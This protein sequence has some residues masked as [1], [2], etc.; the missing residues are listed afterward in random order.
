MYDEISSGIVLFRRVGND[1]YFLLLHYPAGHWDFPKGHIE[2]NESEIEAAI[3]ELR[4]ET[5]IENVEIYFGF[6]ESIEYTYTTKSGKLSHKKV[7]YFLGETS[8]SEV[9]LSKEHIDYAWLP[10]D[11]ALQRITY[12]NSKNVLKKAHSFLKRMKIITPN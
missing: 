11:L 8:E 4:E 3:R 10:F 5:G 12:E 6:R 7:L 1:V 2:R 9:K